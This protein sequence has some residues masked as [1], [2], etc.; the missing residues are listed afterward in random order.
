MLTLYVISYRNKITFFT[1]YDN[2]KN[3][4]AIMLHYCT[5]ILY[6]LNCDEFLSVIFTIVTKRI[7]FYIG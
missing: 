4:Y 2:A 7:L 5:K 3:S 1:F 6:N